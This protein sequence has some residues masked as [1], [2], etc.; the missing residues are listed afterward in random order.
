MTDNIKAA[1]QV[2]GESAILPFD[3]LERFWAIAYQQGMEDAAKV[4]ESETMQWIDGKHTANE[5]AAAIRAHK[6][7]T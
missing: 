4:C 2:W 5:F 3:D 1:R 7:G 6:E